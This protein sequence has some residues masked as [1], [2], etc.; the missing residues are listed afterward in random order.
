MIQRILLFILAFSGWLATAQAQEKPVAPPAD[1]AAQ[2][3]AAKKPAPVLPDS[4]YR[5]PGGLRLGIDLSRFVVKAFQPYRTDVSFAA[6]YRYRKDLY[7][8]AEAGW[9]GVSHSDSNYT[10]KS[11]GVFLTAGVDYNFLKKQET[12]ERYM[13]YGGIRY[14]FAQM[15]YEAP[16]YTIYDSYWGDKLPG[17][18][19]KRNASAHWV[20]LILGIKA[21]V[22]KNFFVGWSIREKIKI[23]GPKDDA[24][25]P[26]VI[27][28][29]G[30]GTKGSQF[31]FQYTISYCIPLGDVK[32]RVKR[33]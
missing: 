29:F 15:S 33:K 3:A 22:L 19:P 1:S 24:F 25:P 26:I 30:S 7:I 12:R 8:A 16:S 28:G 9:Q 18:F 6:D 11:S 21:E 10:Y 32:V 17:S 27:P 2:Q 13:F 4:I 23:S 31:D 14:G 20:E 5:V